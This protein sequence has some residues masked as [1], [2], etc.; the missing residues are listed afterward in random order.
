MLEVEEILE[1]EVVG[2]DEGDVDVA[3]TRSDSDL[4]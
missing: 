3:R 1:E 4:R 2:D